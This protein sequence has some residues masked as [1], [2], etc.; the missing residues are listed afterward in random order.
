MSGGYFDYKQF[1]LDDIADSLNEIIE[2][3]E[4]PYEE[5]TYKSFEILKNELIKFSRIVHAI[6]YLLSGDA[7]EKD[8]TE[9][10]L[11]ILDEYGIKKE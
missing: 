6:D 4:Y 5:H 1:H 2:K 10:L 7:S 3:K 8:F 11:T 9:K